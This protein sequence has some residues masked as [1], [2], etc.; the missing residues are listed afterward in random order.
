[1]ATP[2]GHSRFSSYLQK[3]DVVGLQSLETLLHAL[4]DV[5]T[6]EADSV[7]VAEVHRKT[8]LGGHHETIPLLAVR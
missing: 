5:S 6:A 3:V 2:C 8:D 1:M 7:G 4:R